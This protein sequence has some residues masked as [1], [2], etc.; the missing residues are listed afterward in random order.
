MAAAARTARLVITPSRYSG[1][2]ISETF[3][4]P[5]RRIAVIPWAADDDCRKVA[6]PAVLASARAKYGLGDCP[7]VLGF[8]AADPRKNTD[9]ILCAWADLDSSLRR[10]W[11]L[12]LIGIQAGAMA[13]FGRMADDLGVAGSCLLC[14][15]APG[16]DLP[17]LLSGA[18]VLCYPSLSEGFGLPVLNGFACEAAVLTSTAGSLPEVAGQA[19]MLVDPHSRRQIG[20]ALGAMMSDPSMRMEL[21]RRGRE[22]LRLFTWQR[23]AEAFCRRLTEVV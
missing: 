16:E 8:G 21:V 12:L 4:V 5:E 23:A 3:G 10:R 17:A 22:R 7:Y 19:A 13:R 18:D 6:D 14:G 20:R 9:R 11:R 1:R 2:L 15:Y